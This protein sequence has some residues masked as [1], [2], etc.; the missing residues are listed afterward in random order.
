MGVEGAEAYGNRIL[1][2]MTD[3]DIA[4][5]LQ[6][7]LFGESTGGT[8]T[9]D[10][11]SQSR[12]WMDGENVNFDLLVRRTNFTGGTGD[13]G[14]YGLPFVAEFITPMRIVQ[15]T[16][17]DAFKGVTPIKHTS[18]TSIRLVKP[19]GTNVK[20]NDVGGAQDI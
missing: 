14:I 11:S 15:F 2:G 1:P 16:N 5:G 8:V 10:P 7:G 13:I 20:A 9:L 3:P 4:K 17:N 12:V 6:V 18:G 19:D